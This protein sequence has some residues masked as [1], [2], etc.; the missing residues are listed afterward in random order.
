MS[1]HAGDKG[2]RQGGGH[3]VSGNRIHWDVTL[4]AAMLY[5][6]E[7][8]QERCRR[9]YRTRW[10]DCWHDLMPEI[11]TTVGA[12]AS[13][14]R[15][16]VGTERMAQ[17]TQMM[18]RLYH[19]N[20]QPEE[21]NQEAA[22]S[23]S[24]VDHE[25]ME[26]SVE[27]LKEELR[28]RFNSVSKD[29]LCLTIGDFS[30]RW[31]P[32]LKGVRVNHKVLQAADELV[33]EEFESG[34]NSLWRL[35]CLVYAGAMVVT[36]RAKKPRRQR[37]HT[38]DVKRD[39]EIG[40]LRRKVGWLQSD[41]AK[42]KS[43]GR[44]TSKQRKIRAAVNGMVGSKSTRRLRVFLRTQ[45]D[46]LRVRVTQARR[47][48]TAKRRKEINAKYR[49]LRTKMLEGNAKQARGN[50]TPTE[51]EVRRYWGELLETPG[52][53]DAEHPT[54]RRWKDGLEDIEECEESS[55]EDGIFDVV[56]KKGKNW[57]AAG[58]NGI[59]VYWW[60]AFPK[61]AHALWQTIKAMINGKKIPEWLVKGRTVLIP[62]DG[63]KGKPDQYRPIT[64]LN[65]AYKLFT[66]VL[67]KILEKH[68]MDNEILPVEQKALRKG[69]RGC[70]D[71]LM[72]DA[73]IAD[74]AREKGDGL[75]VAWIDYQ[76]AYDRVPHGWL[77]LVLEEIQAPMGVRNCIRRLTRKWKTEFSVGDRKIVRVNLT[78]KRG[79]FQGDSLSPLLFCLSILPLSCALRENGEGFSGYSLGRPISHLLFMDDLKVYARDRASLA[80]TVKLVDSVSEAMGMTMGLRKCAVA[81]MRW[82]RCQNDEDLVL[83][84]DRKV[85]CLD[86]E[87]SYK[88]LGI[89]QLFEP[90]LRKVKKHLREEYLRRVK[91]IWSTELSAR[92][93][94]NATNTWAV[95]L[96]RYSFPS[97]RWYRTALMIL[98]RDTRSVLRGFQSHHRNAALERVYLPRREGGRGLHRLSHVW[99]RE[100][101]SAALY[102]VRRADCDEHL[103]A[104]YQY[105]LERKALMKYT[106]LGEA[107]KILRDRGM[108][109]A[110]AAQSDSKQILKQLGEVQMDS[111]KNSLALKSRHSKYWLQTLRPDRDTEMCHLWLRNGRFAAETEALI[112][113]MQDGVLYTREFRVNILKEDVT[114]VCRLCEVEVESIK[115]ILSCCPLLPMDAIQRAPRPSG[116]PDRPLPSQEIQ[117]SC[118]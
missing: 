95:A 19:S 64:V 98:D 29:E 47:K 90:K 1:R 104:V 54:I 38:S 51:E 102:L 56:L 9:N 58:R 116:V 15:K 74:C 32:S 63:C 67:T 71:A 13:Q 83:P 73:M 65:T 7:L 89:M 48:E 84:E 100:V 66:G 12:L 16:I 36:E 25:P 87:E 111:M 39:T 78:L 77:Q 85:S 92:H 49:R 18:H 118:P 40:Q 81:H 3:T 45:K 108:E 76:K 112:V 35:N 107:E 72:I 34:R 62:K 69:R 117:N 33:T 8:S 37:N 17:A 113:A 93:K 109:V 30:K 114:K 53:F 88:Y 11:P 44:L 70:F 43:G 79:L 82:G 14:Y 24:Q 61:A 42:R 52:S 97:V 91:A 50:T 80:R 99:E 28:E 31:R 22:P 27:G 115:H 68:V 20:D 103:R 59:C 105:Q 101:V 46:P 75:S 6:R 2:I 26:T 94:V 110:L 86:S 60:K 41:L 5:A 23:E 57:K 55:L 10:V 96:F 21:Q 4:R 106:T